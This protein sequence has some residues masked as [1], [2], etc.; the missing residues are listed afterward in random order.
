M[1]SQGIN[2]GSEVIGCQG[3]AA[4]GGEAGGG[5]CKTQSLDF[6]AAFGD[7]GGERSIEAVPRADRVA[8]LH[9][10][11]GLLD[12]PISGDEQGPSLAPGENDGAD[13]EFEQPGSQLF[14]GD[15]SSGIEPETYS[16]LGFI[17]CEIIDGR[18]FPQAPW[19]S[20]ASPH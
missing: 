5:T 11:S 13:T 1:S 10:K 12:A 17:G 14:L 15:G 6:I 8:H 4:G 2:F 16:R 7:R 20:H 19:P 18:R 9:W 3:V